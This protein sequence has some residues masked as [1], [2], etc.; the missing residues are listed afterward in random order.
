[1]NILTKVF[2]VLMT[3]L[4]IV[5]VS[6]IIPFV[7]NVDNFREQAAA[8][9]SDADVARADATLARNEL[10]TATKALGDDRSKHV[11]DLTRKDELIRGLEAQVTTAKLEVERMRNLVVQTETAN[12]NLSAAVK[13]TGETLDVVQKELVLRR[14]ET[15]KMARQIIELEAINNDQDSRVASLSRLVKLSEE[16]GVRL[17]SEVDDVTKLWGQVSQAEKD[18]ITGKSGVASGDDT[19]DGIVLNVPTRGQVTEVRQ[20]NADTTLVQINIGSVAGVKPRT[21]FWLHRNGEYL[22]TLVITSIDEQL[23][24]GKVRTLKAGAVVGIGDQAFSG[25]LN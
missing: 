11:V 24:A 8:A 20:I 7:A 12:V 22:G 18:R 13:Q 14:D 4:S 25:P 15:T 16:T 21:R 10:T 19:G 2:V 17:K 9:K 23:A 3:L 6:L 1:M 5:L